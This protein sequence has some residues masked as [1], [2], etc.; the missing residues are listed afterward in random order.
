MHQRCEERVNRGARELRSTVRKD[1]LAWMV[2]QCRDGLEGDRFSS[3]VYHT[4]AMLDL[5]DDEGS[6][7]HNIS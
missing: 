2:R 5:T 4:I 3:L 6:L 1:F 7:N